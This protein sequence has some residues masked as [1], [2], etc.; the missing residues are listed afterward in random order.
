MYNVSTGIM[1]DPLIAGT[2][3]LFV[4]NN[5]IVRNN[6]TGGD[7]AHYYYNDWNHTDPDVPVDLLSDYSS[8]YGVSGPQIRLVPANGIVETLSQWQARG[9]DLHSITSDPLFVGPLTGTPSPGAFQLQPSSPLRNTGRIGGVAS[10]A[11]VNIGAYLSDSD[12][13]GLRDLVPPPAPA[14]LGVR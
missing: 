6:S 9:F 10:G 4:Y 8:F 7:K 11:P 13:I 1:M 12:V 2:P 14:G 5:A 3:S